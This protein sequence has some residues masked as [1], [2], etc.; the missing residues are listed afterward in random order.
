L[1][2]DTN[3]LVAAERLQRA[4]NEL[5]SDGDDVVIAA[6]TAAELLVGVSLADDRHRAT[7]SAFV[8]EVLALLPI[9]PYGLAAARAHA[10]LL[11]EVHGAGQPR[12]AHDLLIAATAVATRRIVVTSDVRAFAGLAGIELRTPS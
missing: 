2:L 5:L 8:E 4:I 7:R 12:G 1:I 6:V 11:T 9:E 3:V 10:G